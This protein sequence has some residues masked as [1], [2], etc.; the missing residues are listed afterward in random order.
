M[1]V[2]KDANIRKNEI[3]DAAASLFADKG[4]DNTSTNDILGAVGIARGTLYHHFK[5]KEDVMD[6]LIERQTE[7]LLA[8]AQK[9][10]Q[11][12]SISVEERILGTVMAL[13]ASEQNSG[14]EEMI[15][16]LHKPQNA[17]MHQ[18]INRIIMQQVPPILAEIIVDGIQQGIFETPY[19]LECM[20]MVVI[21]LQTVFDDGIFE[22]TQQQY[23]ARIEAFIFHL[24]R[25]LGVEQG[26][27]AFAMQL[28]KEGEIE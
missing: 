7:Y 11:E 10:S 8:A 4:F 12:K 16:H 9:A 14:N 13:R 15:E 28:F 19:P 24:E 23:A 26:R 27:F 6:A 21:Y 1:R 18:K 2:V 5:S 17:L 22:L 20:E 3:L 25:I